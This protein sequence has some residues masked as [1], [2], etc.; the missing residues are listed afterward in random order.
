MGA[1]HDFTASSLGLM[2]GFGFWS[3]G[4]SVKGCLV[5]FGVSRGFTASKVLRVWDLLLVV[6][7]FRSFLLGLLASRITH[8]FGVQGWGGGAL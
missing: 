7:R 5:W 1:L 8:P 2:Y 4:L 6:E 3:L